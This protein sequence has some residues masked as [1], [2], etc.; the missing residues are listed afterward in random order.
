MKY[1]MTTQW[2]PT[3]DS[4]HEHGGVW[5]AEGREDAGRDLKR[6]DLVFI[7]ESKTGRPR[8]DGLGYHPGKQGIVALVEVASDVN[9]AGFVQ[10]SE[11][12]S[13]GSQLLW[14]MVVRTRTKDSSHFCPH[15]D[16]CDILGY[17][18]NYYF[19]GW[20]RSGLGELSEEQYKQLRKCFEKN[21]R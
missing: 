12:Y 2:P 11:E 4:P 15:D 14:K 6:G 18:R 13:D 9:F 19:R 1:W 17:S 21:P 8:R 20:H 5:L 10:S 16:V 3:E 7:Y